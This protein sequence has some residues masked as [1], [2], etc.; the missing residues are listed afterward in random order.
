MAQPLFRAGLFTLAVSL[1][2][3]PYLG[4][5]AGER[6][7]RMVGRQALAAPRQPVAAREEPGIEAEDG[8]AT[9]GPQRLTV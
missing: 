5:G 1:G 8:D 6:H 4:G 2:L 9:G 3:L 7:A